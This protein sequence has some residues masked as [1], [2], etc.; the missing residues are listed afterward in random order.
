MPPRIPIEDIH[1]LLDLLGFTP[2]QARKR[3]KEYEFFSYVIKV[4]FDS[5]TIDYPSPISLGDRTT[6]NFENSENFVVPEC[7]DRLINKGYPPNCIDLEHK[8]SLGRRRKGKLDILV[9][10]RN[11]DNAYLM[12]ECK[13]HGAEFDREKDRMCSIDGGQLFSYWQ[14]DRNAEYLCLYT[15]YVYNGQVNYESALIKILPTFRELQS[16]K[17]VFN[18]WDKQFDAKGLFEQEVNPYGIERT[19]LLRKDLKVLQEEDGKRIYHQ[20]LEILRHNVISDKGNAF[21]KIFNLFL[22]KIVD[23][24]KQLEKQL[25]FQWLEGS[26]TDMTLLGRL[27]TLYKV[28]MDQY[29]NKDVTDY[30]IDVIIQSDKLSEGAR[31]KI[32][33]LRLF[34][35]QEFAFLE[36]FNRESFEQNARVVIEMIKLLER[37]QIRYAHK[38]QFLGE[39]F[40]LLLNT[41]FK[42]ESG[43][44]FTPLPLVRFILM[45]LPVKEIVLQKIRNGDQDFLPYTIDFSCGSG[46]FLTETMD[47][48]NDIIEELPTDQLSY[49]QQKKLRGFRADTFGWAKE[50]VYGIEFDYRL[51]KTSK[52]ACFLNGDGEAQIIHGSGIDPFSSDTYKNRLRANNAENCRFDVLVANPPYSVKGFKSVVKDGRRSFT[53]FENLQDNSENIEILFI[54]RMTQLLRPGGV[55]GIILPR[56]IIEGTNP[57]YEKTRALLLNNFE[58][59]GVMLLGNNAFMATGIK[60]VILFLRKRRTPLKLETQT[61][62]TTL[63]DDGPVVV[64]VSG[65][66]KTEKRFLGYTFSSRRGH[67]GIKIHDGG[68]LLDGQNP[69]ST[70]HANSYILSSMTG[71]E[72]PSVSPKL[73]EHLTIQSM[74]ELLDWNDSNCFSNKFVLGPRNNGNLD[75]QGT[76]RNWRIDDNGGS[77]DELGSIAQLYNGK[78]IKEATAVHGSIPVIAG[79]RG[80]IPY[81]H[82]TPN[83]QG[84]VITV[85]YSGRYAGYVW[86]HDGPIWASDCIVVRSRDENI[87]LTR[88]LYICMYKRQEEIY[89]K[90]EGSGQEHIYARHIQDMPIPALDIE[91]QRDIVNGFNEGEEKVRQLRLAADNLESEIRK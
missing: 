80:S 68:K 11:N 49:S 57:I 23:E 16:V 38:Q 17:E 19:P 71:G 45:S 82:D 39:F 83:E 86:W 56:S 65:E 12:I 25:E 15:S 31:R 75:E 87:Y 69:H 43:Q 35:N 32:E 8:W 40:E 60:T 46:H 37:W 55:A 52:L 70:D 81:Y 58:L 42:Q 33:E 51:A 7:V 74:S 26:D 73:S 27:N 67:E 41:G 76:H 3:S 34:K 66:K 2:L 28:G 62:Y 21:N 9:K 13:T 30:S 88:Y 54:E 91:Q 61:D 72:I 90:Q 4:D 50:F 47:V 84:N 48:L 24:D 89:E 22:C 77:Y 6:S 64:V 44:F 1:A 29:L 5:E 18:R 20:F 36:V 10:N 59:K 63:R 53:L 78:D 85:S 14:Q 79:G